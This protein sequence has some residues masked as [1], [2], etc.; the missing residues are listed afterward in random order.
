MVQEDEELMDLVNCLFS[1]RMIVDGHLL[2][3]TRR[4]LLGQEVRGVV[5]VGSA[6]KVVREVA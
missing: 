6:E 4:D 1:V 5:L 3:S 2:V